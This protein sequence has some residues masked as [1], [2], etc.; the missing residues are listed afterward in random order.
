MHTAVERPVE[1]TRAA[2]G[3]RAVVAASTS[4]VLRDPGPVL[5]VRDV[6]VRFGGLT[7]L[8]SVSLR[9]DAD[10]VVGLI[11]TNG[12]GKSTLMD[13]IS[14]FVTPESG[15]V[16][17]LGTEITALQPHAR[18][19]MGMSRVFQDARLFPGLTVR[20]AV[21]VALEADDPSDVVP[22]LGAFAPA[23]DAEARKSVSAEAHLSLFGLGR[24]AD[25]PIAELSTGT[26]RIVEMACLS[27]Q[28]ARLLLLDEP[29]AGVAQRETEAM[30][31]M[32]R[33]VQAELGASVLVIEH[34]MPMVMGLSDRVYCL[35]AGK[36]IA[37]G[38]PD[39]VRHD[40]LVVA[41]YLGT[42]DRAIARSD[43]GSR[44]V[45]T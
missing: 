20:E 18:A 10:E 23:R 39:E 22:V 29:T 40:P 42:D 6:T 14:G 37:S 27:A 7:A 9:V 30:A 4:G 35:A 44:A 38:R 25:V 21:Q 3:S 19:R 26:R 34:D 43:A 41:A 36:E 45:P 11:G 33:R 2:T 24:Y 16:R 13:V 17:L 32:I 1:P 31:P 8:S 28:G 15:C 5:E 12:A